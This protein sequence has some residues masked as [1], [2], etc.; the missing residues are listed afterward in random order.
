[1][2]AATEVGRNSASQSS[3]LGEGAVWLMGGLSGTL[4]GSDGLSGLT[5]EPGLAIGDG[6]EGFPDGTGA[7]VGVDNLLVNDG[8]DN[9]LV[10]DSGDVRLINDS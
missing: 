2:L 9:R 8:G 3:G 4:L 10:N 6:L 5:H 1:M 7:G